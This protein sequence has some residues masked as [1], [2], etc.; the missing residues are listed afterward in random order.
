MIERGGVT[1]QDVLQHR[2]G[3]RYSLCLQK[4]IMYSASHCRITSLIH[5]SPQNAVNKVYLR[6]PRDLQ[7]GRSL[8]IRDLQVG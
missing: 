8:G 5:H 4:D 3:R 2:K 1:F 7:V 6:V